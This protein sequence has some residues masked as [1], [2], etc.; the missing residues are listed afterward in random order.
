M[1]SPLAGGPTEMTSYP[2][3]VA[4]FTF[5][6]SD[7]SAFSSPS[8]LWFFLEPVTFVTK[9]QES[10]LRPWCEMAVEPFQSLALF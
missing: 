7:D 10:D 5:L 3:S 1:W 9:S 6:S 2:T 4:S 8:F